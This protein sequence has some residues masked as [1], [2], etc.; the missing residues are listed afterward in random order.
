MIMKK[1]W[2]AIFMVSTTLAYTQETMSNKKRAIAIRVGYG[3]L[4][5]PSLFEGIGTGLAEDIV[6]SGYTSVDLSG[7]GAFMGSLIFAPD[8]RLS[9]GLDAIYDIAKVAFV[10]DPAQNPTYLNESTETSYLSFL[11]RLDFKYINKPGFKLYSSL[12]AG[13]SMRDAENLTATSA[14]LNTE[15]SQMGGSFHLSPLGI[16]VGNKVAFWAE[17]GFGFRGTFSAGIALAL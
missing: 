4:T 2:L 15:K 10:Y 17:A 13:I 16:S 12:A 3:V 9:F 6:S 11:G 14:A 8:S 7:S 5:A 1:I